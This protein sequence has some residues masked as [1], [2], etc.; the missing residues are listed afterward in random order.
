MRDQA[1]FSAY[2]T[3]PEALAS[4]RKGF[5]STGGHSLMDAWAKISTPRK[6][7]TYLPRAMAIGFLAPFPW[8]WFDVRGSTGVM[9]MFAGLEM[10]LIYLLLPGLC[11]GIWR[12][13][14]ARR[15]DGFFLVAFVFATAIPISLVVANLGTLFRLRLMYLLP[16]LIVAASGKPLAVYRMGLAR[17][18]G[19]W[20]TSPRLPPVLHEALR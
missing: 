8:Q 4:Q 10:L 11:V 5:V 15:A 9:R 1:V 3:T 12:T 7:I 2:E 19:L 14:A 17:L 20:K 16:L 18:R 13:V 6:L